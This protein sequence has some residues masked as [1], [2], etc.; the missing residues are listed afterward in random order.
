[1]EVSIR[2]VKY[3]NLGSQPKLPKFLV[4]Y[5]WAHDLYFELWKGMET[6]RYFIYAIFIAITCYVLS[7]FIPNI[8]MVFSVVG[9][10]II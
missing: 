7:I 4:E 3:L 2:L 6:F 5:T 10:L 9:G 8:D 1:M